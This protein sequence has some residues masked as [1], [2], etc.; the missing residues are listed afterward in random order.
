VRADGRSVRVPIGSAHLKAKKSIV[1]APEQSL[2]AAQTLEMTNDSGRS[3]LP[4]N[5]ALYQSGAFL[6]MTN[7]EFVAN[8]EQFA[9]FLRVAD[10]LKLSR[11]LDKKH[12]ALVRKQR[13]QMQRAFLVAVE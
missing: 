4:G 3:F 12:S 13:T 9:V 5:V 6:G 10:Q 2:N 7:V 8:G 11:A 1:A